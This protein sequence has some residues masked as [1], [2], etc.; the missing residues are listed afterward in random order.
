MISM[1]R[2]RHES[3]ISWIIHAFYTL[4][5]KEPPNA[6]YSS[7]ILHHFDTNAF[8]QARKSK[9]SI[10]Y[11]R[12]LTIFVIACRIVMPALSIS[13]LDNP[14]VIQTLS[15]GCVWFSHVASL[16]FDI[17]GMLFNRVI[18]TPFASV[19]IKLDSVPIPY[20]KPSGM[21][22]TSSTTSCSSC[23]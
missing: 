17:L 20:Y 18:S 21:R 9:G 1:Q 3:M 5:L 7:I 6:S 10:D 22:L 11:F 16:V 12:L 4:L 15:A 2:V 14:L 19:Y 8:R 23:S 13:F